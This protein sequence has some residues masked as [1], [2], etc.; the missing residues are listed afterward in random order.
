MNYFVTGGTGFIGRYLIEK[1][2]ARGG[3][4]YALVRSDK[5]EQKLLDLFADHQHQINPVRG[6]IILPGLGLSDEAKTNLVGK[7]DHLFH[8]AAIYNLDADAELQQ[9]ANVHGTLHTLQCAEAL[10]VG[11]FHH[12]SSIAVAGLYP[13]W[14]REDM[15]GQAEHLDHPYLQS[16]HDAEK[17]VRDNQAVPWRIYRPGMVIG[18]SKT[19]QADKADGPYYFFKTLQKLR[20]T[21]PPWLPTI[22]VEGGYLNIVPVDFVVAAMDHIAHQPEQDQTCFH[23]TD[24]NPNTAGEMLNI[25]ADAGHAPR[26][27]MRIDTRLF[28]FIPRQVKSGILK[29]PPIKRLMG[30]VV[31]DLGIPSSALN[32]VNYP[33]RFD[34]QNTLDALK[35]SDITCPQLADY[36]PAIWDY[37]ERNL[38]PELSLDKTLAGVLKGKTVLITGA[39]SGIG[40]A[41]AKMLAG[42]GAKLVLVARTLTE[43]KRVQEELEQQGGEIHIHSCDLSDLDAIELMLERINDQH[44][45]I[46]LLINNA[47]RSIRRSVEHSFD[48][49][50]DYQRTMQLNY[51]GCLKLTMG[52]LPGMLANGGGHVINLS[53]IGVLTNAPRFSA[54]V[55]SKSAMESFTRCAASEFSDRNVQFTTIN[56]PLVATPMIAPTEI[57]QQMPTLTPEQAAEMIAKA[58]IEKPKRV[59]TRLGIFGAL[60]HAVFPKLGEIIMNTGFRMF[61]DS[62]RA[63]EEVEHKEKEKPSQEMIAFAALLRGI[64]L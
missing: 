37:W 46:D 56:M 36:A 11:C 40:E 14:F 12:I 61:P 42:T 31:K 34:C 64:H 9:L 10:K 33:T 45:H 6:D 63:T 29:M 18:H 4:V 3:T 38:D 5:A 47:G 53:S 26:M 60:I 23:L 21:L 19:G 15:F 28:N 16:K 39:T 13:G 22:G 62:P 54:Y 7:I 59:A 8:L 20:R 2:L 49:F 17:L 27:A 50:H 44:L 57:Y 41:T 51:F 58:I 25:F 30:A 24:P 35:G 32:F 43:L 52:L 55:A 1:L 48:R